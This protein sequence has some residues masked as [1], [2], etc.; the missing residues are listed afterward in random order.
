MK[1]KEFDYWKQEIKETILACHIHVQ[2]PE[3]LEAEELEAF[4]KI[5][6]AAAAEWG[7]K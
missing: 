4:D 3:H 6:D 1:Q 2:L 5:C 7:L